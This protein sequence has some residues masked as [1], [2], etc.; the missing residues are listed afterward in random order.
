[1]LL[2]FDMMLYFNLNNE[3]SGAGHTKC[4]RGPQVSLPLICTVIE[5]LPLCR[6]LCNIIYNLEE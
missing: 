6:Q 2:R 3:Y 4:S 5:A 1:M